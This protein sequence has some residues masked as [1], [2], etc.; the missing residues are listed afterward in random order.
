MDTRIQQLQSM[1]SSASSVHINTQWLDYA[2]VIEY[3][4]EELVMTVKAG[5]PISEIKERLELNQQALA[6]YTDNDSE[7]IG[8]AYARGGQDISDS[9]L[10]VQI[11]DG[12]G[13]VL[14]FGGQVMKN[15]A[16]YD[17]A[18]LLVGS[19]GQLAVVTQISFKV[20]P[21]HYVVQLLKPEKLANSSELRKQ[22]EAKLKQVFDPKGIFE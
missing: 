3:Y 17:V 13:E 10:G 7:S 19:A 2:G 15:V 5:T 8:A 6:F 14:N 20:W 12:N 21:K 16:G 1:I 22:I 9:V 4:P 18:R 11:I